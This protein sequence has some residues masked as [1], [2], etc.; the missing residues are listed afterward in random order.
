VQVVQ[1][2]DPHLRQAREKRSERNLH[3][4]HGEPRAETIVNATG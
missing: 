3:F 4:Q 1:V 2:A